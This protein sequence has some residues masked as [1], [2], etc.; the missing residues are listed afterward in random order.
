MIN[1]KIN[2]NETIAIDIDMQNEFVAQGGQL[3]VPLAREQSPIIAAHLSYCRTAGIPVIKTKV[4]YENPQEIPNALLGFF[5]AMGINLDTVLKERTLAVE[6]YKGLEPQQGD[7]VITKKYFDAFFQTDLSD[8]LDEIDTRRGTHTKTLVFT[9]TTINNC[10]YSTMLGAAHRNYDI[11]AISNGIS[12]F[13]GENMQPWYNQMKFLGV[14]V[15]T[16]E[17]FRKRLK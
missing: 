11:I 14:E 10:V 5:S 9:G 13:P 2:A 1:Q 16:A 7:I 12:G 8:R 17:E 15:T 6:F 4:A 3:E